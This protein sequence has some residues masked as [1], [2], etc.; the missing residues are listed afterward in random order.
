MKKTQSIKRILSLL[1][2]MAMLLAL[3]PVS[4]VFATTAES[5]S[6]TDVYT[7]K[8]AYSPGSAAIITVQLTNS[9]NI[10]LS[11][12]VATDDWANLVVVIGANKG[13]G[14]QDCDFVRIHYRITSDSQSWLFGN[15]ES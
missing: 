1:L 12:S 10:T 11:D 8:A 14:W 6:I 13:S 5:L 7:D 3:F 15:S 2:C 9:A 4:T